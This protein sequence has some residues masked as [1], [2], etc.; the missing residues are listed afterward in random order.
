MNRLFHAFTILATLLLLQ[1]NLLAQ[2]T[3]TLRGVVTD[4]QGNPVPG[5]TVT[6][7]SKTHPSVNNQ[8]TITNAKGEFRLPLLPPGNDYELIAAFPEFATVIRRPIDV[9]AGRVSTVDFILTEALVQRIEVVATGDI[10]DTERTTTSTSVSSEFL[11]GLPIKGRSYAAV[12]TLAPGVTDTDGDGN[13]NVKGAREVD[14]QLRIS[15]VPVND[16]FGGDKALDFNIEAFEEIQ[17][18]TGALTAELSSQGGV[19]LV[20]TR[21]G[22]NEFQGS[23]KVFYQSRSIDGDGANNPDFNRNVLEPPSFRTLRP[24]VTAGGAFKK[25][26][27]WYFTTLEY[28]DEQKPNVLGAATK[29]SGKEGHRDFGKLTWQIN[30]E[31]KA[32]LEFHF[33]PTDTFGNFIGPTI[34]DESDLLVDSV[35]RLWTARETWVMSPTVFLDSTVSFFALHTDAFPTF[36][37]LFDLEDDRAIYGNPVS[38]DTVML[39]FIDRHQ[40]SVNPVDENYLFDLRFRTVR[41][42]FALN[43]T[44]DSTQFQVREDLSFYVEDFLGNHTIKTGLEWLLQDHDEINNFR[45]LVFQSAERGLAG[46]FNFQ[47]PIP[48][49]PNPADAQRYNIAFYVQDTWKPIPNLTWNLGV[50]VDR[51][52]VG[53]GGRRPFDPLAELDEYNRVAQLFYANPGTF[54]DDPNAKSQFINPTEDPSLN[55]DINPLTGTFMCDLNGDGTCDGATSPGSA[56]DPDIPPNSDRAVLLGI[57]T[58]DNFDCSRTTNFGAFPA[59]FSGSGR[60]CIGF[61]GTNKVREGTDLVPERISLGNTNVAPRISVSYDPFADGKTKLYATWG[62]F[63]GFLFLDSVV[64]EQRQDFQS[65]T[66]VQPTAQVQILRNPTEGSFTIYQVDRDLRTPF[67]DEWTIGLERELAP[68]IAIKVVFT[69]RKGRDQLQDIDVNH[70]T[71]D[72]LSSTGSGSDG[73]PDD[74]ISG[75][76]GPSGLCEPDGQPDLETINPLFNQIFFLSNLNFSD[77]RSLEVVLSKRLHRNWLFEASYT[78]SEARGNAEFFNSFLGDDPSQVDLEDGFL[79]FDQ[80]HVV[81][82]NAVAHLPKEFQVAGSIQYESGLPFSLINRNLVSDDLGNGTF[83]TIFPT[84]Q[85][86]DQRNRAFWTFNFNLKKAF[87]IGGRVKAL[88]TF[89]IF[90]LLNTDELRIFSINRAATAGLQ[91]LDPFDPAE[92][93][94]GRSFQFGIELHY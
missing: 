18:L 62:R 34:A 68:E 40:F 35:G 89:D 86:N 67:T 73:V 63:Y 85:R 81:K 21:S 93:Q 19:G 51:E 10:V 3:G 80:R 16:P 13:P 24:F 56:L 37:P 7:R 77:Y 32:S 53:A 48:P 92:R 78:W 64:R 25:D 4:K 58:R 84:K 71:V 69:K 52:V 60:E 39:N 41:G 61:G 28:I 38:K 49:I 54:G 14:F 11:S 20:T 59:G 76:L 44:F 50:R 17:I 26:R 88:A 91:I 5:A 72:R 42:P 66:L 83:R 9:D 47:A 57:F 15:G 55:F 30:P 2:E 82:F 27:L 87:T 1:G 79:S 12:L 70:T 8:G 43:S 94:F 31:H 74:C 36:D 90:D 65:F 46:V 6:V 23:L 45:P 33:E 75:L 22:G 29:L